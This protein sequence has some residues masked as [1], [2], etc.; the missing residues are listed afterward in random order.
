MNEHIFGSCDLNIKDNDPNTG[1]PYI[2]LK[3][4]AGA[5]N[6]HVIH[7]TT[8][9]G[10]MIGGAATGAR[11]R[12]EDLQ[13][14]PSGLKTKVFVDSTVIETAKEQEKQDL[15]KAISKNYLWDCAV[16]FLRQ[17]IPE[18][19]K[20]DIRDMKKERNPDWPAGIHFNWGMGIRNLLRQN[21]FGEKDFDIMNLDN[22]YVALIEEAIK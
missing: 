10:E 4:P 20:K 5:N 6:Q 9:L 15:A 21:R 14:I 2:E 7:I 3:F 22:I 17:E 11:K 18:K 16:N 12:Y 8:N 13:A 19:I 1:K